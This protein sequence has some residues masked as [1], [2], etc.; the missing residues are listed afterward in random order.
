[1]IH[2]NDTLREILSRYRYQSTTP[3]EELLLD[4]LE[5]VVDGEDSQ[6]MTEGQYEEAG[7]QADT[8]IGNI[9]SDLQIILDRLDNN[10]YDE[11]DAVRH[12]INKTREKI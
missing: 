8:L 12:D 4:C 11:L 6:Y 7:E 5:R 10:E 3:L 2:S 1:M 9:D